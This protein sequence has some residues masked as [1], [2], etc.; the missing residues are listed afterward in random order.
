[1]I[2]AMPF[3]TGHG[4]QTYVR[5][6]AEAL[7]DAGHDVTLAVYGGEGPAPRGVRVVQAGGRSRPTSGPQ[8]RK[9]ADDPRLWRAIRGL[10]ADVVHA[11]HVEAAVI[12]RAVGA[13]VVYD[14]HTALGD[15]LPDW[16]PRAGGLAR[17]VGR[18]IDGA[19]P[20]ACAATIA[21][22]EVGAA[23]L[24]A[25][26]APRVTV[27][28]VPLPLPPAPDAASFRRRH[29]LDDR[30]WVAYAGNLDPYQRWP[31]VV[32]AVARDP[33]LGLL[34]LINGD[35]TSARAA[36]ARLP[37]GRVRLIEAGYLDTLAGLAAAAVAVV[38]RERCAGV[39]IKLLNQLAIGVPSVVAAGAVDPMPGTT[40]FA[41]GDAADLARAVRALVDH[42]ARRAAL[43]DAG[44]AYIAD[45]HAPVRVAAALGHLYAAVIDASRVTPGARP[46]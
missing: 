10:R 36:A 15:E 31:L 16:F 38:P 28:P 37:A 12:G 43:A 9:L 41:P 22:S 39:P 32:D 7:A 29:Q 13:P 3:P 30:P 8:W 6:Q 27:V 45:V 25:A 26:G 33:T 19:V 42:P 40:T 18:W 23:T 11:H 17:R 24:R 1:M 5:L 35:P 4:S 21:L 34:L 2:A 46:S 14:A 44:R 20:S